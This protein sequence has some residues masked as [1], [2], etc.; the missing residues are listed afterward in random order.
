MKWFAIVLF[1][2]VTALPAAAQAEDPTSGAAA[3][4]PAPAYPNRLPYGY[5]NSVI[6][7]KGR[8][9][10]FDVTY[11]YPPVPAGVAPPGAL[12]FPPTMKTVVTI[13]DSDGSTKRDSQYSGAFQVVGV[14]RYAVYAVLTDYSN[15]SAP[16]PTGITRRLV[17][18]GPS[19]PT[20]PSVDVTGEVQV[21]VSAVGD[22][23]APDM[24]A[25]VDSPPI[26]VML[27][28]MDGISPLAATPT[29]QRTVGMFQS[30]GTSF[31]P[32]TQ[33][34]IPVP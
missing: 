17:A 24:I 33:T 29:R 14:G 22:D 20:L 32:L 27:A 12:R 34:P 8:L 26:P 5:S 19:F 6:D 3:A 28:P 23:G 31:K 4:G 2:C 10:V 16:A 21:R 1:L 30:D 7:Q 13:I 9:L 15:T 11:E 18:L 25:L